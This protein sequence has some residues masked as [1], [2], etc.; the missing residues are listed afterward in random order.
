MGKWEGKSLGLELLFRSY[1]E[2]VSSIPGPVLVGKKRKRVARRC[3]ETRYP[4][5]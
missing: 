5:I 4:R 1:Q 2:F 3:T